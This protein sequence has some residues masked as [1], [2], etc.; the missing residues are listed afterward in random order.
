MNEIQIKLL[1]NEDPGIFDAEEEV[2]IQLT[3]IDLV[4]D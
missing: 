3:C 4:K 2:G 1:S